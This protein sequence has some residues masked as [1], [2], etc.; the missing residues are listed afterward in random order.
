MDIR[1]A[2]LALLLDDIA[3][4]TGASLTDKQ[5]QDLSSLIHASR[6]LL[7]ELNALVDKYSILG[8][9]A[10]A[11]SFKNRFRKGS[12]KLAW[13]QDEV[14]ELRS[15]ITSNITLL[16]AFTSNILR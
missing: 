12:K 9:D 7:E 3:Q 16:N 15:R 6:N 14:R 13:D 5:T 10:E 11:A 8:V 4:R 1:V 2:G